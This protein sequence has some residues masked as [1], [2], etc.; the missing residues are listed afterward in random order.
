MAEFD[1]RPLFSEEVLQDLSKATWAHTYCDGQE[2]PPMPMRGDLE[3]AL[4][5]GDLDDGIPELSK[6]LYNVVVKN[7]CPAYYWRY[8]EER[9]PIQIPDHLISDC[10]TH[11]NIVS[12]IDDPDL[13][14][15]AR[16]ALILAC[17]VKIHALWQ[18]MLIYN[19]DFKHPLEPLIAE[20]FKHVAPD[21]KVR[22]P[23]SKV[24]DEK[25]RLMTTSD[26]SPSFTEELFQKLAASIW[27]QRIRQGGDEDMPELPSLATF[28]ASVMEGELDEGLPE[29]HRRIVQID[30]VYGPN[31]LTSADNDVYIRMD[32]G[33]ELYVV[34]H[35]NKIRLD[36]ALIDRTEQILIA[37]ELEECHHS[38]VKATELEPDLRHPIAPLVE[39]WF[40]RPVKIEPS[41]KR[42]GILP[43]SMASA[44]ALG[45]LPGFAPE[46]A[47]LGNQESMGMLPGFVLAESTIIP[48]ALVQTW[49]AGGGKMANKGQ[50]APIALRIWFGLLT[51]ITHEYRRAPGRKRIE[52][53]LRDLRNLIYVIAKNGRYSFDPKRDIQKLRT[54]LWEVDQI[55]IR[56]M[57]PG[58]KAPGLWR[59]V[60]V[61][62]MPEAGIDSPIVFDIELPPGSVGGAMIDRSAMR[63]FGTKSAPKYA[64]AIGLPYYWDA[65][66]THRH[67]TRPIQATRPKV[68][69][70]KEG[71]ALGTDGEVLLSQRNQPVAG[72]NDDRLVFLDRSRNAVQGRTLGERRKLAARERNPYA[73]RYPA[74]MDQD[75][76]TLCFPADAAEL[77]GNLRY[78]RLHRAKEALRE[79][80]EVGYCVIEPAVG[81]LGE[82]GYRILPTDWNTFSEA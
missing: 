36:P 73:D 32:G 2:S 43:I 5:S 30:D 75:V 13:R 62:L 71:L 37:Y 28:R 46:E 35:D 4:M 21:A 22:H 60:G 48:S 40:K 26:I 19:P 52:M 79:M 72:F 9:H 41:R 10:G 11:N 7:D 14:I 6:R 24:G 82:R 39:Q 33:N 20:W 17:M 74:L 44:G 16:Q 50:G 65:F 70:N 54:S 56:T 61:T 53:T 69:R 77:T 38:W 42:A 55:R 49:T 34:V 81:E 31:N 23:N 66:G 1:N 63:F 8:V 51:S 59:P 78:Q 57:L 68:L 76:L 27:R 80:E 25:S 58:Y 64:A 45:C 47:P 18:E 3:R 15:E 12:A 29:F 67:G